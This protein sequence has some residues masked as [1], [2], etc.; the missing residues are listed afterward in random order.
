MTFQGGAAFD[1][2]GTEYVRPVK[3]KQYGGGSS[4]SQEIDDNWTELTRGMFALQV[5]LK[6]LAS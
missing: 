2:N 1:E 6:T 4:P 3:G 5:L